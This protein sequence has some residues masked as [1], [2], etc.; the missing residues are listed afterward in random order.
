V[1]KR[2]WCLFDFHLLGF[3]FFISI[4]GFTFG[5]LTDLLGI[6]P[7]LGAFLDCTAAAI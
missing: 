6:F 3:H 7:R 4:T 5:V 2:L 1:G